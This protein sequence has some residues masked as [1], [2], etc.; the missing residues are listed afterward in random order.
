MSSNQR[1]PVQIGPHLQGA[2]E[3]FQIAI[4]EGCQHHPEVIDLRDDDWPERGFIK[5]GDLPEKLKNI[6]KRILATVP[7][8]KPVVCYF[9]IIT[10][11]RQNIYD[12]YDAWAT[13]TRRNNEKATT[14]GM[15]K[16]SPTRSNQVSK[17][18]YVGKM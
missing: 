8:K 10:S 12:T 17:V 16:V 9:E 15:I 11:N 14:A 3:A 2:L 1:H 18:L 7:N 13:A 6:K 4:S 5:S